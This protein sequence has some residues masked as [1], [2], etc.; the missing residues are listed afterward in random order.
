MA[1][2]VHVVILAREA[3]ENVKSM[4]C[5]SSGQNQQAGLA[6]KQ[7]KPL[8][9]GSLKMNWD[10][11][12]CSS[13]K[14]MGV[15][16]VLRDDRGNVRAACASIIP[17]IRDPT[18]AKIATLWKVVLLCGELGCN[19]VVFEGDSLQVVQLLNHVQ[20]WN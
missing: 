11:A 13:T 4:A 19:R 2:P 5:Q 9:V 17:S 10:A 20:P 3:M 8:E 1:A 16:A 12:I 14:A 15:G 6:T 18:M 7:W